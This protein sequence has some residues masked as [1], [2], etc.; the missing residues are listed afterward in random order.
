MGFPSLPKPLHLKANSTYRRSSD[1]PDLLVQVVTVG[2]RN[3]PQVII[4]TLSTGAIFIFL[5]VRCSQHPFQRVSLRYR[6]KKCRSLALMS[7]RL[8]TCCYV[9]VLTVVHLAPVNTKR[10]WTTHSSSQ[11]SVRCMSGCA[12]DQV[13][14]EAPVCVCSGNAT[15]ICI[16]NDL[17]PASPAA[18]EGDNE[19]SPRQNA[20]TASEFKKKNRR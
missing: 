1:H 19:Q 17:I 11:F 10:Y 9:W 15:V 8:L 6:A 16:I 3:L 12:G 5:T 7:R 20:G 18:L 13:G 4:E 2:Q 14:N